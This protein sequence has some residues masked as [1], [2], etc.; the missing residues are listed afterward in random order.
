MRE[1]KQKIV[2][3]HEGFAVSTQKHCHGADDMLMQK[4]HAYAHKNFL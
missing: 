4:C 2:A 1:R 3:S